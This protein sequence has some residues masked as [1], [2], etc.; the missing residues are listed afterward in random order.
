MKPC[1]AGKPT[2]PDSQ[3]DTACAAQFQLGCE[4]AQ[5][6]FVRGRANAPI[7]AKDFGWRA[8]VI[9]HMECRTAM[10]RPDSV[11]GIHHLNRT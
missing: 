5:D 11:L 3:Y 8:E 10:M 1:P 9:Q 4:I 7:Q 2:Y 6:R